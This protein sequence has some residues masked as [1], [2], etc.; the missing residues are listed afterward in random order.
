M[1]DT[2]KAS[3]PAMQAKL[4]KAREDIMQQQAKAL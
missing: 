3:D 4:A 2:L 1:L